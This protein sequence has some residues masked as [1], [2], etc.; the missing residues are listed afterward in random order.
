[1]NR[2][3]LG[4]VTFGFL[5]LS[6]VAPGTVGTLGGVAIAWA[7]RGSDSFL[8]WV[9]LICA[10]LY[11]LGRSLGPWT[12][13]NLGKDPGA[14]VIDEVIGYLLT[15]AWIDGPSNLALIVAFAL[16]RLF[17]VAKPGPVKRMEQLPGAD[18]IL[19]DDVVAGLMG[20][21]VMAALRFNVGEPSLW[22]W[23]TVG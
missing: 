1:M 2:C 6:P 23:G 18:G 13:A 22:H 21:A 7:L 19:L 17:D 3:K 15:V 8:I 16:F 5:G 9:L 12:E 11:L 10:L 14:F 4:L 20:L